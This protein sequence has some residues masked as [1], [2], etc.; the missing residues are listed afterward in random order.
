MSLIE[1]FHPG[2][3]WTIVRGPDEIDVATSA[4]VAHQLRRVLDGGAPGL[5]VDL[6]GT[7]FCDCS[8]IRALLAA[9]HHARDLGAHVALAAS[10]PVRRLVTLLRL[11][12]L[13]SVHTDLESALVDAERT[14]WG[15]G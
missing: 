13:L 10:C 2:S 7:R 3:Q 11:E 12:T 6:L 5:V 4:A 14:P 15:G 1:V 8:G 9:H